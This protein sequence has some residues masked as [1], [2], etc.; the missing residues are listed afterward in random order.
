MGV[1]QFQRHGR[2][3]EWVAEEL[4]LFSQSGLKYEL[5][6]HRNAADDVHPRY[7]N[8]MT[9]TS[10]EEASAYRDFVLNSALTNV[11]STSHWAV[12]AAISSGYGKLWPYAYSVMPAGIYV[13]PSVRLQ[14][15][16]ELSKMEVVVGRHSGS[17]FSAIYALQH[18]FSPDS[19]KLRFVEGR[20]NRLRCLLDNPDLAG[21][22]YGLESYILEQNGYRKVL[23]TSFMVSFM[24]VG[25][26]DVDDVVKYFD[27]LR[28]AQIAIDENLRGPVTRRTSYIDHRRHPWART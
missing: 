16:R 21:S 23:D 1:F 7:E 19:L 14:N 2:I 17:H 18:I 15:F 13:G 26:P 28:H 10:V 12:S 22:I 9:G 3:Q 25:E 11:A 5:A 6:H 20:T 8:L 24:I 27:G 4:G